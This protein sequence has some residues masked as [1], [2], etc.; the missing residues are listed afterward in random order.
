MSERIPET[1]AS[2]PIGPHREAVPPCRH[3]Q[4]EMRVRPHI[5]AARQSGCQAVAPE[6]QGE[7]VRAGIDQASHRGCHGKRSNQVQA[8][9]RCRPANVRD[10]VARSKQRRIRHPQQPRGQRGGSVRSR[11][12]MRPMDTV[13]SPA[14]CSNCTATWRKG[15]TSSSNRWR[16]SRF[17]SPGNHRIVLTPAL[18]ATLDAL[19]LRMA[20]VNSSGWIG[21][22]R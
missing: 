9:I 11:L 18:S 4:V 3:I 2:T 17:R 10:L 20:A 15:G 13:G 21:L 12:T 14:R 7:R 19:A 1:D 16:I 6:R 5:L 8:K 22:D